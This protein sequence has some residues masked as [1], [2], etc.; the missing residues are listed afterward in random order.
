MRVYFS[1]QMRY[2]GC[3]YVRCALPLQECGWDG[4]KVLMTDKL[5]T[6]EEA[7][8]A[9]MNSDIIVFQRPFETQKMVIM[10]ELKKMGKKFVFDNDDTYK[11]NDVMKLG[12]YL[13]LINGIID[14]FIERSDLVTTTNEFLA[15]EY[16]KI[17]PN[18]VVLPNCVNPDDFPEPLRNETN[19]VRI[20]IVGSIAHCNDMEHIKPLL[21]ELS[22]MPNVQLVLFSLSS[23]NMFKEDM[24]YWNTLN[25]EWQ[26]FVKMSEYIETLNN[27]KLDIVLIPRLDTYFNRC[28]SNIKFLESSM[29]EIPVVAQTFGDGQ[30]PYDRDGKYLLLANK[31]DEWRE[32]TMKLVNDKKL[33][34]QQAKKAKEYVLEEYNIHTKG[35]LWKEAYQKLLEE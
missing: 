11:V 31:I 30:S 12:K 19:K 1:G 14:K 9:M 23:D 33:R 17:N 15:D 28:K 32:Q 4:D 34:R 7:A 24:E 8:R 2:E 6:S 5:K 16:R 18:V 35:H 22:E 21:S 10:E 13:D 3:Y 29:L 26:P 20:G 27:L 25:V